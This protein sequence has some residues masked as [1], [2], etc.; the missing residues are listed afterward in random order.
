MMKWQDLIID[1][2]KDLV[3]EKGIYWLIGMKIIYVCDFGKR[4]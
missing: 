3:Y 1:E 2:S 4:R